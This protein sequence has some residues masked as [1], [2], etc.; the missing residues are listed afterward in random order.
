MVQAAAAAAG[1]GWMVPFVSMS[2]WRRVLPPR[3][4][5]QQGVLLV[6]L[7]SGASWRN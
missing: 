5:Q 4:A 7:H 6:L 3:L 2:V 1:A